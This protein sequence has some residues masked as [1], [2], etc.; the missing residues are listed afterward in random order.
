MKF[1]GRSWLF[2]LLALLVFAIVYYLWESLTRDDLPPGFASG[3]GRIEAVEID[4]ATKTPGRVIEILVREGDFVEPGQVLAR[5][6]TDVL[7]AQLRE[8]QAQLRRAE[9]AVEAAGSTV[10]QRRAER[11][12]AEAVVAQREAELDGAQRRLARSQELAP[13]G[14]VPVQRLDDDRAQTQSARAAVSAAEAQVAAADAAIAAAEARIVDAEAEVE[15]VRATIQRIEADIND[16]FLR[17]PRQGR[18]QYRVAELGEVLPAG[19]RVLNLVDLADVY[20]TFFLPTAEAGRVAIG[21]EVRLVMDAAPEHVIPARASFVAD[22]A[23]FTPRTVETADERVKLMFRIRA[24]IEPALLEEHITQVKT[25]LPGMAYVQ[26][27]READWP[28]WL[29]LTLNP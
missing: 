18:V 1:S 16:S 26:L 5:M 28:E 20:M 3:N 25:G 7:E 15:A 21:S 6:D 13:R 27:D 8:A 12:A 19:G 9:I 4:V 24:R 11:A 2:L 22:V 14:T 17:A 29:E 23:Q 10:T